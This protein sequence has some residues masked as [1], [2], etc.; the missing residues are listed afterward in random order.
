MNSEM[1][2]LLEGVRRGEV[3]VDHALLKIKT[4]LFEDIGYAKIDLHRKTRQGAAEVIY[5]AGKTAEQ[6][7]GNAKAVYC[8]VALTLRGRSKRAVSLP[9]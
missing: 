1:R 2:K 9:D 3:S 6:I 7:I 4:Q 5:G 8:K